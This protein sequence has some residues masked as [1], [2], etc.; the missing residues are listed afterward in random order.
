VSEKPLEMRLFRVFLYPEEPELA[1]RGPPES[2][3][4]GKMRETA[5]KE[6]VG[7]IIDTEPGRQNGNPGL[8]LSGRNYWSRNEEDLGFIVCRCARGHACVRQPPPETPQIPRRAPYYSDTEV[9][10]SHVASSLGDKRVQGRV[11]AH[12]VGSHPETRSDLGVPG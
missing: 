9:I 8:S 10:P 12:G 6:A 5:P 1:P 4:M 3:G 7:C 11:L 2:F